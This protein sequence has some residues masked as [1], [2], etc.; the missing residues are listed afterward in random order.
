MTWRIGALAV[1][2]LAIFGLAILVPRAPLSADP[3]CLT[4]SPPL[5]TPSAEAPAVT[6]VGLSVLADG[7]TFPQLVR[8]LSLQAPVRG[9]D[10]EAK[11]V[12]S[13]LT[14]S[15]G[16]TKG[17]ENVPVVAQNLYRQLL[18]SLWIPPLPGSLTR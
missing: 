1:A 13:L 15:P 17:S 14:M 3:E 11:T 16:D 2:V 5:P 4:A 6:T 18:Q 8:T 10:P 9:A 12:A 7:H